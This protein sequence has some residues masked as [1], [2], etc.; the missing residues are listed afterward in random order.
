MMSLA[1]ILLRTDRGVTPLQL[2]QLPRAPF[3]AIF[4][5]DNNPPSSRQVDVSPP[6]L[7][8]RVAEK[9]MLLSCLGLFR[10]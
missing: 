4:T 6:I 5:I 1:R 7:L 9:R 3:F 8:Q 10:F 2:L